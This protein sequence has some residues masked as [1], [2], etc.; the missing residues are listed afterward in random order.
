MKTAVDSIVRAITVG[1]V[2][3]IACSFIIFGSGLC[4]KTLC[5]YFSIL[6]WAVFCNKKLLTN[7]SRRFITSSG[8]IVATPLDAHYVCACAKGVMFIKI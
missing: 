4:R 7:T 3:Q 2:L 5:S 8:T 1:S 6:G